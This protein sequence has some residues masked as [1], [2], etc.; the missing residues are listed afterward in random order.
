MLAF[1]LWDTETGN[2][3]RSFSAGE[4]ALQFVHAAVTANGRR[5]VS[6]WAMVALH[7]DESVETI[8]TG[9]ALAR[10]AAMVASDAVL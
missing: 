2:L 10:R 9:A 1:E 8:A 6:H 3:I 7:A 5:Y 4:E